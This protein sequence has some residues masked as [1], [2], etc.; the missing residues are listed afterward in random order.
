MAAEQGLPLLLLLPFSLLLLF[1]HGRKSLKHGAV[2]RRHL[3][4]P[5][6]RR[7]PQ[8]FLF[9]PP[10]CCLFL[11]MTPRSDR[12]HCSPCH[13]LQSCI[14]QWDCFVRSLIPAIHH[15]GGNSLQPHVCFDLFLSSEVTV[16]DEGKARTPKRSCAGRPPASCSLGCALGLLGEQQG[17]DEEGRRGWKCN[18][19]W[20]KEVRGVKACWLVFTWGWTQPFHPTLLWALCGLPGRTSWAAALKQ[21]LLCPQCQ[22]LPPSASISRLQKGKHTG[23]PHYC[24]VLKW[25]SSRS[26]CGEAGAGFTPGTRL[27]FKVARSFFFLKQ[28][29]FFSFYL[30][31]KN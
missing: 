25:K 27:I 24:T 6:S 9:C 22:T 1:L 23:W 16:K 3:K 20:W 10:S 18:F 26:H 13:S 7:D 14:H 21:A 29:F 12:R 28:Y 30:K 15:V 2:W 4:L 8:T 5:P 31:R 11:G 17:E 19:R